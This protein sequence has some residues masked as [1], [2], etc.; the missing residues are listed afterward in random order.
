MTFL[1]PGRPAGSSFI[2]PLC[3]KKVPQMKFASLVVLAALPFSVL[4]AD[5]VSP[6]DPHAG[7]KMN[8]QPHA[9]MPA[10]ALTQ[11]GTVASALNSGSYSYIEVS[12]GK[13]TRWLATNRMAVNKGDKIRFDEGM[14]MSNFHSKS[15]N[16][17]FPAIYFVNQV[18]V[19]AGK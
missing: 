3:L 4:A 7:M 6:A 10:Q 14:L 11:Q 12:Q 8:G 18:V 16:R 5:P 2:T 17:T 9:G 13:G 19:A 1:K 15:L